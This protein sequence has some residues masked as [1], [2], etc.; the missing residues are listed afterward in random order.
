[1][2]VVIKLRRGTAAEWASANPV[3]AEAEPGAEIDTGKFKIGNGADDWLTLDYSSGI[4]GEPFSIDATGLEAEIGEY[5]GEDAGFAFL[6][7]DTGNLYIKEST[8][9]SD[10]T[11]FQGPQGDPGDPIGNF[12]GGEPATVYTALVADGGEEI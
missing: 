3:L 7:T 8:G 9:W 11:P 4:Q 2:A 6:A 5:D 1:M 10:P 12:D